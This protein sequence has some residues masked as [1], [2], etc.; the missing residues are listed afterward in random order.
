M[1]SDSVATKLINSY[2]E[3]VNNLALTKP[4]N[5]MLAEFIEDSIEASGTDEFIDVA[6]R[7][8]GLVDEEG[9]K[10]KTTAEEDAAKEDDTKKGE[11]S[12]GKKQT[13]SAPPTAKPI[14][15]PQPKS[16]TANK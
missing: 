1:Y 9:N 4:I 7:E 16:P 12:I 11:S 8:A 2:E 6:N 5:S 14:V 3:A 15:T 10:T 13:T